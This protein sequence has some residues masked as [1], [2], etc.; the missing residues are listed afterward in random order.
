M[1]HEP[2]ER[3]LVK[4]YGEERA[5]NLQATVVV[6]E[7]HLPEFIHKGTDPGPRRTHHLG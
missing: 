3:L 7:A 4:N 5:V 2:G 6:D 1:V